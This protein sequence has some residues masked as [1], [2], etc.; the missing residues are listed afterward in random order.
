M[1]ASGLRALLLPLP[2]SALGWNHRQLLR[3]EVCCLH[4]QSWDQRRCSM[5]SQAA[6][7][8]NEQRS[9][10]WWCVLLCACAPVTCRGGLSTWVWLPMSRLVSSQP[11]IGRPD[12]CKT[13][14]PGARLSRTTKGVKQL[15]SYL[16]NWLP[17]ANNALKTLLSNETFWK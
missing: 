7:P 15:S 17:S 6:F 3:D 9:L 5:G 4:R 2:N 1:E 16:G 14:C 10:D 12:V 13:W 8:C 11:N